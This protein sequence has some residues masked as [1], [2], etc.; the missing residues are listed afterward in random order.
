LGTLSGWSITFDDEPIFQDPT[1]SWSPQA[2]LSDPNSANPTACPGSSTNYVLTIGNGVPGC[3]TE[4]VPIFVEIVPCDGCNPPAIDIDDLNECEPNTVD[5]NSAILPSSDNATI[6]FHATD[7]DASNGV[8]EINPIVTATG[9]YWVRAEDPNDEDCFGTHSVQ[10]SII[11]CDDCVPPVLQINDQFTCPP[12]TVDLN[13]AID[14]SS[15][16]ASVSFYAS[17][18]DAQAGTNTINNE[19]GTSGTYWIRAEDTNDG[20]C[21]NVFNVVVDVD[22]GESADFELT[23][24]CVGDNNVANVTGTQGGVFTFDP[25][26][27]DGAQ[28]NAQ[29]GAISNA[30]GGVTYTVVYTTQGDCPATSSQQVTALEL[31]SFTVTGQDLSCGG[32][33][34]RLTFSGLTPSTSYSVS[35]LYNGNTLSANLTSNGNGEIVVNGLSEGTYTNFEVAQGDCI[36]TNGAT[37]VLEQAGAPQVTAPNDISVCVGVEVTDTSNLCRNSAFISFT[38]I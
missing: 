13:N 16:N 6:S 24:F 5:L 34:G 30:T 31:P 14:P 38:N 8:N 29:T 21:F 17:E 20:D 36:G 37:V 28:I 3:A 15:D 9:T 33:D 23:D 11:N 12:N 7:I 19:V 2:G 25:A 32:T 1:Y 10:V 26:P 35:Y 18:A 4:D 22:S 27:T